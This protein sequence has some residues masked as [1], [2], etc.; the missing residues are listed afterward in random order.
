MVGWSKAAEII[1][2][3]VVYIVGILVIWR[4]YAA[5]ETGT[6]SRTSVTRFPPSGSATS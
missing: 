6:W 4:Q 2:V 5:I 1:I 3:A